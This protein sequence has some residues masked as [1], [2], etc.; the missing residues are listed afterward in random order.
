MFWEVFAAELGTLM[1][2][3]VIG[4]TAGCEVRLR[5]LDSTHCPCDLGQVISPSFYFLTGN[6]G[7]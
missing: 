1:T 6:M 2:L 5:G 4:V 3:P 7:G